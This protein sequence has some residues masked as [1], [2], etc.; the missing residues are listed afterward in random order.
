M[1]KPKAPK[2]PTHTFN[3]KYCG[4]NLK[5][6]TDHTFFVRV[7]LP[8][9]C[10][11]TGVAVCRHGDTFSLHTGIRLAAMK[12]ARAHLKAF[13]TYLLEQRRVAVRNL[14]PLLDQG[15]ALLFRMEHPDKDYVP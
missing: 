7:T 2:L 6:L 12:A 4:I 5:V 13:D 15:K 14:R 9:R 10:Q 11:P 3:Y 1:S 8:Y